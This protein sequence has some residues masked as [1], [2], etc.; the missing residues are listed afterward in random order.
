MSVK[1]FKFVSPGVFTREVDNSQL[2]EAD[3]DAGPVIIGRLPQGPAMEPVKIN[4]FSDF[5]QVFGNPVPGKAT[6]DVWRHGNR[7]GPTYASY[8]AQAYLR[9]SVDAVTVIRLAGLENEDATTAGAAGWGTV[10]LD[11]SAASNGG[12][13]GLFLCNPS[14]SVAPQTGYLSAIWYF[15]FGGA[16][17]LSGTLAGDSSIE[18]GIG[19]L[20]GTSSDVGSSTGP[21][22]LAYIKD[23]SGDVK[24]QTTFNF[25]PSSRT[26]IRKVFNTNPQAIRGGVVPSTNFKRGEQYYWLGESYESFIQK[27]LE[28]GELSTASYGLI[29][30]FDNNTKAFY[31]EDAKKATTG[32]YF[33]QDVGTETGSYSADSMQKLFKIHALEPGKWIQDSLKISIQDLT[34]SRDTTGTHPY[35]TFSVVVRKAS[36]TDVSV[37]SVERFSNCDLNPLSEN[38]VSKKIGDK[39]RVWDQEAVVMREYGEYENASKYVRVEVDDTVRNGI[40]NPVYLPFGVYGP[41]KIT[42]VT[43]DKTTMTPAAV[44]EQGSAGPDDNPQAGS[45][46]NTGSLDLYEVK[47]K[48]PETT[49]RISSSAGG[50]TDQTDAYFGLNVSAY[51]EN[52]SFYSS[53]KADAGYAD[54]VYPLGGIATSN[55]TPQWAFSLDEVVQPLGKNYSYYLSGSRVDGD[56]LSA[57]GSWRDVVDNDWV[58]FTTALAGG[59]DGLDILDV[60]PF[61]NSGMSGKTLETSYALNTVKEAIDIVSDP[62]AVACNLIA[63][64]GITNDTITN[65]MIQTCET[66]ADALAVVDL[67]NVYLPFTE[68]SSVY[69]D[70]A[71]RLGSVSSVVS[72]LQNRQI[73]TSYACAYYPWVQ[74][75]D[76]VSSNNRLWAP[77]SVAVLG[78]LASSEAQSEVWFAPAGFNRGGLS[79]GS[80]GIP[81]LNVSQKLTS[82]ERDKLYDASINP[83]ASF[84][85]E[86]IVIFGQKTLQITPSA[87]DRINVRRMLILVKKQ[88][89]IFANTILFDQNVEVTWERF[90]ALA[91]PFL[92]SV[93]TRLG[94]SDYKLVLD[95]TTTTPD[96]VDQNIVYARIYLKP[97]KAIEYIALDFVIT[98]QGAGF[99]D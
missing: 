95:N 14:A 7:Q 68:N 85:N 55:T 99:E 81:V 41:S 27:K 31:H 92:S 74:I 12:A 78:T 61:R 8:A 56:S 98:N 57:S 73:N 96:L 24:Y 35:G 48:F 67:P 62:E 17:G 16:V 34:Y 87:L 42:D 66:R 9:N 25:D 93:K 91:N 80:A 45:Q 65:H 53:D 59:F 36:D 51:L 60:E 52:S 15:H 37:E 4:S 32:W 75:Q 58:R 54:Y 10:D 19:V 33:S 77:P 1:K 50:L 76:T 5:V 94:L 84:P 71:V 97:A 69:A 30:P 44:L 23:D 26:F 40:A 46:I 83:I 63:V 79:Q 3:R 47:L 29:L 64:P 13:Y 90:K 22:Y 70:P 28:T 88:I 38:Y 82:K 72:S 89:S 11:T 21:D 39:Y 49:L 43:I 6:G 20:L 18:S 86:G 2:P